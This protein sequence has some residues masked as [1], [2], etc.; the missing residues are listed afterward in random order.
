[1]L[2][3]DFR[4]TSGPKRARTES[5]F[6]SSLA[7]WS[8]SLI[9]HHVFAAHNANEHIVCPQICRNSVDLLVCLINH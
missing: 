2:E 6:G 1:M 5:G 4:G 9:S 3:M 8:F 7:L